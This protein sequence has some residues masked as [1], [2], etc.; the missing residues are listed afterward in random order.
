MLRSAKVSERKPI[1][2]YGTTKD[3]ICLMSEGN[4]GALSVLMQMFNNNPDDGILAILHLDDMNIR[5]TQIWIGYKDH[6][7]QD[8]DKFKEAIFNRDSDM[9][10]TINQEGLNGNHK[11]KA[12]P[13]GASADDNRILL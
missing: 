8:I 6:C 13:S 10:R 3:T 12:V 11:D 7:G 9:I 4:P 5:G 2:F 1:D